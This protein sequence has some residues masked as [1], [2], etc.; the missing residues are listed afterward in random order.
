YQVY[1][2]STLDGPLGIAGALQ[3]AAAIAPDR[4]CGLATLALFAGRAAPIAPVRGAMAPAAGPGLGDGLL[5][6]YG[7][8]QGHPPSLAI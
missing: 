7:A 4:A 6:W 1:L 8:G 2:A 3:A 5:A